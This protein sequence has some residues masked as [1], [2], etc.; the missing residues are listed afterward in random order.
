MTSEGG[1]GPHDGAPG[2]SGPRPVPP[3]AERPDPDLR[4]QAEQL[5]AAGRQTPVLPGLDNVD[6]TFHEL[7]VHQIELE[8]QNEQMHETQFELEISRAKYFDLYELAPVGY[9][10]LDESGRVVEANFTASRLLSLDRHA[11]VGRSFAAFLAAGDQDTY[12]LFLKDM[13]ASEWSRTCEVRLR[14]DAHEPVWL[15]LD[16]TPREVDETGSTV[17]RMTLTDVSEAQRAARLISRLLRL[18]DAAEEVAHAG[19]WSM[20]LR[21]WR[22]RW[23]PEMLKL[24]DLDAGAAEDMMQAIEERVH[25]EDRPRVKADLAELVVTGSPAIRSSAWCGATRACTP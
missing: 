2:Q 15:R 1:G 9:V 22:T 20:D 16:A 11:L 21:T 17:T 4:P 14:Q 13:F 24:F 7:R 25:P 3:P 10:T 18:R 5:L 8:L 12:Y 23:S 19:T 6:Q